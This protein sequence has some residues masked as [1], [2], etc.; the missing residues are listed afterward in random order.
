MHSHEHN[1][2]V[3]HHYG[4]V[5]IRES[6]Y[7]VG[8]EKASK[9]LQEFQ[10]QLFWRD[11]YGHLISEFDSIYKKDL[12]KLVKERPKLNKEEQELYEAW[13]KGETGLELVDAGMRQLNNTG[14]MANRARLVCASV[15]TKDWKIPV[16]YGM[17]YFAEKLLDYDFTQNTM[18][19]LFVAGGYPFSEA[20]FRRHDPER[21]AKRLD[22]EK[23]YI[24][25]WLK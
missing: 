10:R 16:Q 9:S 1:L 11:F 4:T 5:S 18:N 7:A 21:T 8:G 22:P 15:L 2:S 24:N 13:C 14:L 3:H 23:I 12:M 25:T 20:P 17:A 19:W 6:Y